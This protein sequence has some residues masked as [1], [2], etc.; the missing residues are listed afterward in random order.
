MSAEGLVFAHPQRRP[1][2]RVPAT[3]TKLRSGFAHQNFPTTAPGRV[4]ID[5][6][7]YVR[8]R[9]T[10]VYLATVINCFSPDFRRY[11]LDSVMPPAPMPRALGVVLK[12][13]P[14]A[15]DT[16]IPHSNLG[17]RFRTRTFANIMT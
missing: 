2:P 17:T 4:W 10:F 13:Y 3:D 7:T 15:P 6:I 11:A 8:T 12:D 9:R 14:L 16:G 5:D 1:G